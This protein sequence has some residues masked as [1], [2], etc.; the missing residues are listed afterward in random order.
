MRRPPPRCSPRRPELRPGLKAVAGQGQVTLSWSAPRRVA[1]RRSPVTTSTSGP[2]RLSAAACRS[3]VSKG[4]GTSYV[5]TGLWLAPPTTSGGRG[6]RPA[7]QVPRPPVARPRAAQSAALGAPGNVIAQPGRTRVI[8][9][10]TAPAAIGGA[11]VSGY[12]VYRAPVLEGV[13]HAAPLMLWSM[14]PPTAVMGLPST[15]KYYFKVAA[16]GHHGP[17]GRPVRRGSAVPWPAVTPSPVT[18]SP[19]GQRPARPA[20]PGRSPSPPT[21]SRSTWPGVQQ[22][23]APGTQNTDQPSITRTP[24]SAGLIILRRAWPRPPWPEPSGSPST[25]A[26]CGSARVRPRGPARAGEL[27]RPLSCPRYR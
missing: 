24:M 25:S 13:R 14:T 8:L 21:G 20:R 16:V 17:P 1:D 11:K 22:S 9:L 2:P 10:W 3:F 7:A 27:Q 19:V 12:L 5:V 15:T 4:A 18:P 6:Q 23:P 26:A